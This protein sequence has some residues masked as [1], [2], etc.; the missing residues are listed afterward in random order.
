MSDAFTEH[1][2]TDDPE[3]GGVVRALWTRRVIMCLLAALVVVALI[4]LIGQRRSTTSAAV[5]AATLRLTA[6]ATVRGG[7]LVQAR[8][9]VLARQ[10]L[11][12]PSLVLAD[13]W[14][15]G[16]QVNSISPQPPNQN[17]LNGKVQLGFGELPAGHPLIVWFSF[18]V[19]PTNVGNQPFDIQLLNGNQPVAAIHR[20]LHVLP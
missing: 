15:D 19:N 6:P 11:K 10:D 1:L 13:G 5:P 3:H 4:G 9:E 17:A 12:F 8:I 2:P 16:M 20:T 14:M 18:Q 7:L